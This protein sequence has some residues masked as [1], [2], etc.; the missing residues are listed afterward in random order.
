MVD[1]NKDAPVKGGTPLALWWLLTA[2]RAGNKIEFECK[3]ASECQ[4]SSSKA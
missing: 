3:G 1:S 4:S 2:R